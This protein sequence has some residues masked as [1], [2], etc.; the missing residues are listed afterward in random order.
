MELQK[1]AYHLLVILEGFVVY[2]LFMD[3]RPYW[4]VCVDTLVRS[5]S[6]AYLFCPKKIV[7]ETETKNLSIAKTVPTIRYCLCP[8]T[9]YSYFSYH[10]TKMTSFIIWLFFSCFIILAGSN[11]S[12]SATAVF[13]RLHSRGSRISETVFRITDEGRKWLWCIDSCCYWF[14]MEP[15]L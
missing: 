4:P 9:L 11:Y 5:M 1:C 14:S 3:F 6:L 13:P 15:K 10:T 2:I 7:L 8:N 12:S